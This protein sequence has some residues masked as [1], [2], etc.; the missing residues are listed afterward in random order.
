MTDKPITSA[1]L[2]GV[3]A[4]ETSICNIDEDECVLYYRGYSIVDLARYSTFEETAY[5]LLDGELPNKKELKEF[6]DALSAARELPKEVEQILYWLPPETD[7]MDALK[8]AVGVLEATSPDAVSNT[9][10][11]NRKKAIRLI[12]RMPVIIATHYQISKKKEPVKPRA[13][14][15]IAANF[16]YMLH[17]KE[18]DDFASNILDKSFILY[19]EHEFNASTFAAR[20]T[21]STLSD[22]HS[23]IITAIG[24]LKGPLHGGANERVMEMLIEIGEPAKAE[25]WIKNALNQK[26]KIMGFGHR[27]YKKGDPRNP[28]VKQF[29]SELGEKAGENRWFEISQIVEN[30]VDQEKGLHANLD[31][32]ASSTY[33]LMGIPIPLYTP[34]F[35][36]ARVTGWAAHVMEQ[37]GDNRLIR[38][39]GNYTGPGKRE[40]VSM[41]ERG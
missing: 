29:A 41:D 24:T 25:T 40:Y 20:I 27:V 4:G 35:A 1:G 3:I 33:Y 9:F 32:Y 37:H 12:S 30:I 7:P 17:G 5:L 21:A 19:A 16:L 26:K 39:R 18:P 14:L 10:E 15:S 31:F 11:D 8:V 22:M 2:E 38:P 13:D 34:L 23:A 36:A 6:C 28:F